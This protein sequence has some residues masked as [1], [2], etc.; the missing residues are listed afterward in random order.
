[1]PALFL[2]NESILRAQHRQLNN[3]GYLPDPSSFTL[4]RTAFAAL[5]ARFITGVVILTGKSIKQ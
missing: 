2:L 4:S 3:E 1:M 5:S